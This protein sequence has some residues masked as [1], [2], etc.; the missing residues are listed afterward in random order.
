MKILVT[1]PRGFVGARIMQ[2]PGA[3]AAPSLRNATE[4]DVK[5]LVAEVE[6]DAIVHTAAISDIGA[7]AADPEASWR[8]NVALPLMI[9]RTGVKSVLLSTDQVYSGCAGEGPYAE[10]EAV[11]T[12]AAGQMS[13]EYGSDA[14]GIPS[15]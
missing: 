8:A 12:E 5:R 14:D 4:D 9:A 7:C 3:V 11:Q 1:G 13:E 6:P 10:D 2:L 15:G